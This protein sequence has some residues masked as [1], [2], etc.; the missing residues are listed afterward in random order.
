MGVNITNAKPTTG[1]TAYPEV[2]PEEYER[3][4]VGFFDR[5]LLGQVD[6]SSLYYPFMEVHT[7]ENDYEA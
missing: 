7:N 5:Y 4:V 3:Q 2:S 1:R 6:C